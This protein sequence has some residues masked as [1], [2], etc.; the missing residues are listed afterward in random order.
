M[1][2]FRYDGS[3]NDA[4]SGWALAGVEIYVCTQPAN[5]AAIPPSPLANLYAD[6]IGTPFANPVITDGFGNF[7]FYA[8]V[9]EYTIVIYDPEGRTGIQVFPDQQVGAASSGSGSTLVAL[10]DVV[11]QN[12]SMG[13]TVLYHVPTGGSGMY[14]VSVDLLCT[15]AGSPGTVSAS[16]QW[17]NGATTAFLNSYNP[18]SLSALG[19]L[20]AMQGNFYAVEGTDI[21]FGTTVSGGSGALYAIRLRLE[22]IQTTS[23]EFFTPFV[24]SLNGLSGLVTLVAGAN[25]TI[26]PSGQSLIIASTGGGGGGG[27]TPPAGDIGGSTSVPTVVSTHLI[28]PLPVA[29]GG[30]GT[31]TPSIVAGTNVT[32]TGTWPNQTINSSGGGGGGGAP[33]FTISPQ[34]SNFTASFFG[35]NYRVSTGSGTIVATLPTAVGNAGQVLFFKKADAGSGTVVI[36]PIGAQTIDGFSTFTLGVQYQFMGLMSNGV[37]WDIWTRN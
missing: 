4:G 20:P 19:E 15:Q 8:D 30:T 9:G 32:V 5:T 37:Q 18:L 26:T 25:T 24:Q 13:S 29:Q 1:A 34:S 35:V 21:V 27:I 6:S 2:K 22:F 12:L 11:N 14:R 17:N 33:V 10:V 16:V 23:A 28:S 36:T 3:V 31:N 7:F